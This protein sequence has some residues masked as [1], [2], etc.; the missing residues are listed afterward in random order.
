A[1]DTALILKAIE[2]IWR[3]AQTTGDRT[4]QRIEVVLD[5]ATAR[6]AREGEN[7]ARWKGHLEHLLKDAHK[8]AH[9]EAMAYTAVPAFL[10]ELRGRDGGA[11]R[12]LEFLALCASRTGEVL[13]ARWD[14]V[15]LNAKTWTIPASRMKGGREH[16]VPLVHDVLK[17]LSGQPHG[18]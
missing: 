3:R 7:P 11:A 14:E 1:I 17:I 18:E 9:H 15:D 8:V 5:W 2:P 6:G 10:G 13:G 16:V 4:R 12:A